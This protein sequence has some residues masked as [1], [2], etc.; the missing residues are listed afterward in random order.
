M[1]RYTKIEN[2]DNSGRPLI[3]IVILQVKN[4]FFHTICYNSSVL[5]HKKTDFVLYLH[6]IIK[7]YKSWYFFRSHFKK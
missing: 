3:N 2:V 4:G 7:V 1:S 5:S 6:A